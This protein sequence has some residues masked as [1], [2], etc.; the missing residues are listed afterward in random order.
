[1]DDSG[2]VSVIEPYQ[3]EPELTEREVQELHAGQRGDGN[4]VTA[5]GPTTKH[6]LVTFSTLPL[7]TYLHTINFDTITCRSVH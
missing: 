2:Q 1:M 6:Q 5:C 3:F 4:P 7:G